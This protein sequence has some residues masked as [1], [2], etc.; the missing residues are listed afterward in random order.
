MP[1]TSA[2]CT[3]PTSC[4][5]RP[6][7]RTSRGRPRRTMRWCRASRRPNRPRLPR[8]RDTWTSCP[9]RGPRTKPRVETPRDG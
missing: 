5:H 7:G 8:L 1:S 4:W 9:P 3:M 6:C 2:R